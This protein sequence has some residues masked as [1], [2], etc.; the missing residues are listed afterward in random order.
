MRAVVERATGP[1]AIGAE[2][3]DQVRRPGSGSRDRHFGQ[4]GHTAVHWVGNDRPLAIGATLDAG[5]AAAVRVHFLQNLVGV[6]GAIGGK[7]HHVTVQSLPGPLHRMQKAGLDVFVIHH[8]KAVGR[9]AVDAEE[10]HS[11][12]VAADLHALFGPGVAAGNVG[13]HVA[14]EGR[15]PGR[16]ELDRVAFGN[17]DGVFLGQRHGLEA[18]QTSRC[19]GLRQRRAR[20]QARSKQA[21]RQRGQPA[22]QKA[23]ARGAGVDHVIH[24]G[25]GRMVRGN[26]IAMF[27]KRGGA[28]IGIVA[29]VIRHALLHREDCWDK[30]QRPVGR[31]LLAPLGQ[32][33]CPGL[34]SERFRFSDDYMT[35]AR[36][37]AR[38]PM[39]RRQKP[40]GQSIASTI[41]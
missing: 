30:G 23:A 1:R 34:E 25:V 7:H 33:A 13:R 24:R 28:V 4:P 21:G 40:P 35:S 41:A 27:V 3:G 6:A 17:D 26:F 9:R 31:R 5:Y 14:G 8:Q 19:R 29:F 16:E 12:V 18:K 20:G 22:H 39:S 38:Q 10:V 15:A 2:P 11:V 32:T 37:S 36:Q